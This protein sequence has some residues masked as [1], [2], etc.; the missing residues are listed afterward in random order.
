MEG[1]MNL[2]GANLSVQAIWDQVT[3]HRAEE[4]AKQRAAQAAAKAELDKVHE[5][6]DERVV[7]PDA[8]DKIA[9]VIRRAVVN[10]EKEALVLRFPTDWLPDQGRAITSHDPEWHRRL[11][12]FPKRAYEFYEKELAPRG[13]SLRVAVVDYP[14]GMP[15]DC[16]WFL[17]WKQAEGG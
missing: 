5:A 1:S 6:F 17:G 14:G 12:G 13:F 2:T 8:M 15:G 3:A 7:Q 16:G 10:G 4:A 11:E 9:A